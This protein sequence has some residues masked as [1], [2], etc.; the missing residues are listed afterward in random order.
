MHNGGEVNTLAGP[1]SL[2]P[3]TSEMKYNV[4]LMKE[5]QYH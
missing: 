1:A 5:M 2:H 4:R 3:F